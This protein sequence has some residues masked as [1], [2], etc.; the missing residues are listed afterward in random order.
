MR[1]LFAAF[2]LASTMSLSALVPSAS[3]QGLLNPPGFG[4]FNPPGF[5]NP[6]GFGPGNPVGF[7]A[8]GLG[9]GLNGVG[10]FGTVGQLSAQAVGNTGV[11]A[12]G[13]GGLGCGLGALNP[14]GF[15]LGNPIGVGGL[16]GLTPFGVTG[17][18]TG[19]GVTGNFGQLSAQA[20]PINDGVGTGLGALGLGGGGFFGGIGG[21]TNPPGFGLGNPIGVGGLGGLTPFGVTGGVTGGGVGTGLNGLNCIPQGAFIVCQ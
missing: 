1:R 11:N 21:L 19:G 13:L 3:A 18:V 7:G 2:V 6:P 17:G 15:G 5:C 10:V 8:G 16:S 14:P 20:V 9:L 12:V 4:P